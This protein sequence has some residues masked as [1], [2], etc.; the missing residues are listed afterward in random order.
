MLKWVKHPHLV[1]VNNKMYFLLSCM[2]YIKP[3]NIMYLVYRLKLMMTGL[4]QQ[5]I[6]AAIEKQVKLQR[7]LFC[8]LT[9]LLVVLLPGLA[10]VWLAPGRLCRLGLLP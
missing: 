4:K 10:V 3:I 1:L 5:N 2:G 9:H 8:G 6:S 7:E